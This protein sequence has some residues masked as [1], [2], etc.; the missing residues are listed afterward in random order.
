MHRGG[1]KYIFTLS[2]TLSN[3]VWM[4]N[5]TPRPLYP[6]ERPGTHF[7]GGLVGPRAGL[8]GCGKTPIHWDSIPVPPSPYRVAIPT[9][10]SRTT[11]SSSSSQAGPEAYTSDVPQTRGLL[12]YTGSPLIWTFP[13]LSPGAPARLHN[14]RDP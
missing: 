10:L 3:M 13:L 6:R 2:L 12:C 7:V 9:E 8:D 5:A 4:I 1:L 14:A 11:S